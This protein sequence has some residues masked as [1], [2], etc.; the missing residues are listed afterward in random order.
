[1]VAQSFNIILAI[2]AVYFTVACIRQHRIITDLRAQLPRRD[3]SGRFVG[4]NAREIAE[5]RAAMT[6]RLEAGR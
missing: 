3:A 5:R 2:I 4:A 6:E 1:M